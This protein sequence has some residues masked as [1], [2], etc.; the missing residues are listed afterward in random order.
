MKVLLKLVEDADK[1]RRPDD[2]AFGGSKDFRAGSAFGQIQPGI[3]CVER[4]RVVVIEAQWRTGS[5]ISALGSGPAR[6]LVGA[7]GKR[8]AWGEAFGQPFGIA[9]DVPD[10][11]VCIVGDTLSRAEFGIVHKKN[12]THGAFRH[13]SKFDYGEGED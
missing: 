13:R 6:H 10:K 12:E 8:V 11:P 5:Q 1:F 3:E 9:R 4:P 7:I 2:V